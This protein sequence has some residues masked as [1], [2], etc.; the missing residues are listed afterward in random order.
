MIYA[1]FILNAFI[2]DPTS[3][4]SL[5]SGISRISSYVASNL[6]KKRSSMTT[7]N[8]ILYNQPSQRRFLEEIVLEQEE[9]EEEEEEE[10]KN[11]DTVTFA[12]FEK[13]NN[14]RISCLLLGYQ[15]GFQLWDITNPDNVHE[16]CSI[17]DKETFGTV[18]CIHLINNDSLAVM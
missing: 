9:E 1:L 4:E 17:R 16:I 7:T 10:D 6:P 15:N 11:T 2:S 14:K 18:S 13:L 8:T 5:S 12:C 3:F